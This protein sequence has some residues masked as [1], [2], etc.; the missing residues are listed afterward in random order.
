MI[1]EKE[2]RIVGHV[3]LWVLHAFVSG[4]KQNVGLRV[5]TMVD[6][7][8]R[9]EGI[10]QQ[11]TETLFQN[12][13]EDHIHLLYGFPSSSA[14]QGLLHHSSALEIGRIPRYRKTNRLFFKKATLPPKG[15]L[16]QEIHGYDKRFDAFAE[17]I[18]YQY[19]FSIIKDADFFHWRYFKHPTNTYKVFIVTKEQAIEGYIVVK[20]EIKTIKGAPFPIGSIIDGDAFDEQIWECLLTC[21]ENALKKTLFIQTWLPFHPDVRT[22]TKKKNYKKKPVDMTLVVNVLDTEHKDLENTM[23][24]KI[25][26]GDVD[27]F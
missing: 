24:W 27:A 1:Y 18:K 9:Y 4:K 13:R 19:S 5:D 15:Y 14:K 11:L 17:R 20:K 25:A 23:N 3:A 16:L 2:E 12:A 22:S 6:P 7:S 10:Y 8:H 26:M 21:G